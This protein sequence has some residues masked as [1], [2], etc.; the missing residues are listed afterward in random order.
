M[1]QLHARKIWRSLQE[2][3]L[4]LDAPNLFTVRT[5]SEA[6]QYLRFS[7]LGLQALQSGLRGLVQLKAAES[8]GMR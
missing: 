1:S 2:R 3:G 5:R 6:T 7:G 8:S 4:K